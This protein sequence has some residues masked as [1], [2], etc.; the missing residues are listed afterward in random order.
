M[1]VQS[2]ERLNELLE[3]YRLTGDMNV[4]NEIVLMY[5]DL[6]KMIAVSMRNIYT[7]YAESDDI[8]N[9]GVI[10]LMAAIDG[11]DRREECKIRNI[12][13]YQDK[14]RCY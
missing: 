3:K 11:F 8:I 13:R 10:A 7:G 4:R 14:G 12:R 1:A 9:E 2:K 6:V 5:M